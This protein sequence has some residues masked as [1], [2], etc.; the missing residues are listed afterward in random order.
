M[1]H[2]LI[3]LALAGLLFWPTAAVAQQAC[4]KFSTIQ[5][6]LA[7]NHGEKIIGAGVSHTERLLVLFV[8]AAT[9]TWTVVMRFPT[10]ACAVDGGENWAFPKQH[11]SSF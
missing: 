9:G 6:T 3:G 5:E 10:F 4:D 2:L 1:R 11:K 7:E 8:N